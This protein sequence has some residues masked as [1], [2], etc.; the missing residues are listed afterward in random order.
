M[1]QNYG[2]VSFAYL[3][4]FANQL[5]LKPIVKSFPKS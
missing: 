5:Y 4:G 1:H 3:V 2:L